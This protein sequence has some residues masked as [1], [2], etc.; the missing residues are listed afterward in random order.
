MLMIK[1][2]RVVVRGVEI[3]QKGNEIAA[4]VRQSNRYAIGFTLFQIKAC[5]E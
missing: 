5:K 4:D 2:K 3:V 1:K